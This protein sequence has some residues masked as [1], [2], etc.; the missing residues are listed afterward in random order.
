MRIKLQRG[1]LGAPLR[2]RCLDGLVDRLKPIVHVLAHPILGQ[3]VALL[4]LAFE[5]FALSVDPG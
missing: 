2:S 4:D 3:P 1:A 5:L